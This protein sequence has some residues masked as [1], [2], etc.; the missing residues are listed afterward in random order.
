MSEPNHFSDRLREPLN[1]TTRKARRNLLAA[2]VIGLV[3]TRVGLVPEKISAFGI[4]FTSANQ[5]ALTALL[6]AAIL[7][8]LVS[9]SVYVFS[10]LTAWQVVLASRQLESLRAES[11]RKSNWSLS[12]NP[13]EDR[14]HGYI[15]NVYRRTKPTFYARLSVELLI[16][17]VFSVYSCYTLLTFNVPVEAP[18][19]VEKSETAN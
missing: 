7:Y 4:E 6:V 5:E 14:F 18:V 11:E 12:R 19:Q 10:E 17:I 13:D 8:F 15:E 16:P 2:S 3:I 9:F 1:E